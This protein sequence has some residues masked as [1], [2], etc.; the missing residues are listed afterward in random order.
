MK[1]LYL[2]SDTNIFIDLIET[3]LLDELFK[4]PWEIHTTDFVL[5][6]LKDAEQKKELETYV[7][8]KVLKVKRYK[9]DEAMELGIFKLELSRESNLSITDCSV[10]QLA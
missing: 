1:E 2:V 9:G 5:G 7:S 8:K 4:L 10:L 6:E 3:D